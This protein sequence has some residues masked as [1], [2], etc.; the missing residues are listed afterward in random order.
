MLCLRV[1]RWPLTHDLCLSLDSDPRLRGFILFTTSFTSASDRTVHRSFCRVSSPYAWSMLG[2]CTLN[3]CVRRR[4]ALLCYICMICESWIAFEVMVLF[5]RSVEMLEQEMRVYARGREGRIL[6]N[7][8]NIRW[9]KHSLW[10]KLY[11]TT[12]GNG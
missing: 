9:G 7:S 3:L 12:A 1:L 10:R 8:G 11:I 2:R 5:A 6:R 4:R